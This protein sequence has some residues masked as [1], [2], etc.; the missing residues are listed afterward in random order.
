MT[1][2]VSQI[3]KV[4]LSID[5]PTEVASGGR[6]QDTLAKALYH[7]VESR[8]LAASWV[9]RSPQQFSL[10]EKLAAAP[11]RHD[12]ALLGDSSWIGKM[13]GRTRFAREL[14]AR[15]EAAR[16]A[17]INVSAIALDDVELDDHLDL[18]VK[19][20]VGMI[21]GH[22]RG[23]ASLQP[24]S[25]R[26]GVWYSPISVVL[27]QPADW[28]WFGTKWSLRQTVRR[29]I[30][31]GGVAHLV[32]DAAAME[33]NSAALGELDLVLAHLQRQRDKGALAVMSLSGLAATLVRQ[34]TTK[35]ANSILRAA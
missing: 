11:T 34:P 14:A 5:L 31:A 10:R 7:M 20:R 25:I 2:P 33:G 18:L 16:S 22:L 21:R 3:G 28:S 26:F 13:A 19:H 9:P 32:V 35:K 8:R 24:Q 4:V 30:R 15:V 23:G 12:L 29:A 27:P 1:G 17:N 6:L